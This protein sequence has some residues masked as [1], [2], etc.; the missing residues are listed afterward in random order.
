MNQTPRAKVLEVKL[1]EVIQGYIHLDVNGIIKVSSVNL[2][3]EF[4]KQAK[5]TQSMLVPEGIYSFGYQEYINTLQHGL[6]YR[7]QIEE[8]EVGEKTLTPKQQELLDK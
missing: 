2:P 4:L 6:R 1:Q 5:G 3:R 8:I 7:F